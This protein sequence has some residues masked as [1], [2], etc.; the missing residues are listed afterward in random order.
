MICPHCDA[1]LRRKERGDSTCALCGRRFALDPYRDGRGMHDVR[2]RR[3]A[4]R[5]TDGGRLH[6]T[7]T[8]LWYAS[9]TANL[10]TE[11]APARGIRAWVR[12]CVALPAAGAL[13]VGA[14][15]TTGAFRVVAVALAVVL[16][17]LAASLRHRPRTWA[18]ASVQPPRDAFL[19][20]M[21][22]AW[23]ETYG[24]L[25][26]AVVDERDAVGPSAA[27]R[28]R[29]QKAVRPEVLILCADRAVARFLTANR[30]P[31]RLHAL[32]LEPGPGKRDE[33]SARLVGV[34]R[35]LKAVSSASRGLPVVVLHDADAEGA[36]LAPALRAA[37]PGRT[38]VDAGLPVAAVAPGHRAVRRFSV[39]SGCDAG[40][41]RTVAGLPEGLAGR[42]AEGWWSPLAAVPPPVL[43]D[44]VVRA[45]ERALSVAPPAPDSPAHPQNDGFLTWPG[46]VAA[47]QGPRTAPRA[48]RRVHTA[49][50]PH[51]R[52]TP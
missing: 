25:P 22:Q 28:G 1:R 4:E 39:R 44:I 23:T 47:S 6:I 52:S 41:L 37:F 20:L 11:A 7:L 32:L 12:W 38:V 2:V 42:L 24:Q 16:L 29:G 34:E 14:V 21:R 36:L 10:C 31:D 46:P 3:C 45:V 17:V 48:G 43:A 8:Q 27:G 49:S 18:S 13:G 33:E 5:A 26:R 35:A 9:R 19:A 15:L 51:D 50:P 40:L 30:L